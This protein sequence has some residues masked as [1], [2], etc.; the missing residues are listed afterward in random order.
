MPK[1]ASAHQHYFLIISTSCIVNLGHLDGSWPCLCVI[2]PH[3]ILYAFVAYFCTLT[4]LLSLSGVNFILFSFDIFFSIC[5]CN[6]IFSSLVISFEIYYSPPDHI[7]LSQA[8]KSIYKYQLIHVAIQT[9]RVSIVSLLIEAAF[10]VIEMLE[11]YV[12]SF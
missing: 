10:Q 1:W 6:S 12:D 11:S 5:K 4:L 2:I 7:L 3:D 9:C 8:L